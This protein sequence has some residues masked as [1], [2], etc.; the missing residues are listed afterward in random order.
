[1]KIV[2]EYRIYFTNINLHSVG[3][4]EFPN[5]EEAMAAQEK[6]N[7][8]RIDGR[9]C[10]VFFA[11]DRKKKTKE[12]KDKPRGIIQTSKSILQFCEISLSK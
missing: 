7:G 2:I 6:M 5:V 11:E 10:S 12:H 3:F 8:Q 9:M 1:M 4:V